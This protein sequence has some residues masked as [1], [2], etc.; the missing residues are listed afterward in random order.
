MLAN[1]L[2]RLMGE[3]GGAPLP[4]ADCRLALTALLIRVAR[5]DNDFAATERSRILEVLQE[6]YRL[7]ASQAQ[8][9]FGEAAR[10]EAEAGDHVRLTRLI[11]DAVPYDDREAVVEALWDIALADGARHDEEAGFLRLVVSLIG[12]TDQASALARQRVEARLGKQ[13][14]E[15]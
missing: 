8:A 10:L 1:L 3:G 9:V 2:N 11:K 12:V 5:A 15:A 4:P 6:R 13:R 7:T 14:G